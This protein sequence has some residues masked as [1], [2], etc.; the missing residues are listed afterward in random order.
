MTAARITSSTCVYRISPLMILFTLV[1]ALFAGTPLRAQQSGPAAQFQ[2]SRPLSMIMSV[3]PAAVHVQQLQPL[4]M[5]SADF[6]EDGVAD[7]VLGYSNG[8][9]G[10]IAF[11]RGNLDAIAPQTYASWLAA[12][13]GHFSSLFLPNTNF[14]PLPAQPDLIQVADMNGDGHL[15]I[16]FATRNGNQIYALL[17]DGSGHFVLQAPVNVAGAITALATF[18][19]GGKHAANAVMVGVQKNS[20]AAVALYRAA[21][22]ELRQQAEYA[23]PGVA[24]AIEVENLD[25]DFTP[26]AAIIAG[27]QLMVLHGN[28]ALS[29]VARLETLP[30]SDVVAVTAGEFIFDRHAQLQLS[31]LTSD[32]T[33]HILAHQGFDSNPYTHD[34]IAAARRASTQHVG[35]QNLAQIAGNTGGQPWT[36]IETHPGVAPYGFSATPAILLHGKASASGG[37]DIVVLN[38]SQQEILSVRHTAAGAGVSA[39]SAGPGRASILRAPL[40]AAAPI[41]ALSQRISPLGAEGMVVLAQGSIQPQISVPVSGNTLYVNTTVDTLDTNDSG[42]CTS[43]NAEPCSLRDAVAYAN[44]DSAI[45]LS[46]GTVD[47]I[48]VPS[49]TYLLTHNS[50]L[51]ASGN[52]TYH[53]D[54]TGPMTIIGVSGSTIIDANQND[55]IFSIDPNLDLAFN[56]TLQNLILQNAINNNNASISPYLQNNYGGAI[57]WEAFGTGNLN[58]I[59]STIQQSAAKW[60]PGGGIFVSNTPGGAG[61]LTITSSIITSNTTPEEGGGINLGYG[62]AVAITAS[63]FNTNTAKVAN[64]SLDTGAL[65]QGGGIFISQRGSS[66]TPQSTIVGGAFTGNAADSDGGGIYTNTGLSITGNTTISGN[67]SGGSGGG[68]FHNSANGGFAETTIITAANLASNKAGT[69]GGGVAVGTGTSASGNLLTIAGSR[70]YGNISPAG[71]N[72][73]SAGDPSITGA[74]GVTATENWWGCNAGPTTVGDGCDQAFLYDAVNGS[75]S[76]DPHIVLALGVSPGSVNAGAPITLT[77][78]VKNDSASG[79]PSGQPGALL[80]ASIAFGASVGSFSATPSGLIDATAT[81]AAQVTPTSAGIGSATATLDAQTVTTPFTVK[82]VDHFVVTAPSTAIAG[83]SFN[84][85]VTAK[86]S[87]GNTVTSYAGTVHFTSTDGSAVLPANS[88][89]TS[90][91]GSFSV[92]LRTSGSKTVSVVDTVITTATGTSSGITVSAGAATHFSVAAPSHLTSYVINQ[93]TVTALD[94]FGNVATAYAGT[95]QF[96]S[97]DPGYVNASGNGP[98]TSGVGTFNFALKTAGIQSITATDS[99]SATITGATGAITVDPGPANHFGI[100]APSSA[101]VGTPISLAVTAYDLFGNIATTY[102]GTIHFTTTDL[103]AVLP[104]DST[105]T[106]GVGTFTARLLTGGSQAI[107]AT[108][109]FSSGISGTTSSITVTLSSFVVTVATDDAIGVAANCPNGGG[110]INCSLRDAL[111][112]AT[113]AGAANITFDPSAFASPQTITLGTGG[114]LGINANTTI[115]G[116]TTG[117]GATLANLVTVSGNNQYGVLAVSPGATGVAIA[118]LIIN[119]GHN[120]IGDGGGINNQGTLSVSHSTISQNI[121][122]GNG[123]GIFNSGTLTVTNSTFASN[124]NNGL[125]DGGAIYNATSSSLTVNA[126][127]FSANT[128]GFGAGIWNNGTL[129]L[130]NSTLNGQSGFFDGA[131]VFNSGNAT[132]NNSTIYGNSTT[133]GVG[134]GIDNRGPLS[135]ANTIVLQN[136][137]MGT[138]PDL[139]GNPFSDGGGNLINSTS[140]SHIDSMLAPLGNYGGLTQ[141]MLPLPG[142][143][144][145][146]ALSPSSATGTDQRGFARTTNYGGITCQDSGSVQ[147]SYTHVQFTNAPSGGYTSTVNGNV[148]PAP[149]VALTENGQN[150]GGVP[151]TLGINGTSST[152]SGLGPLTTVPE[153]VLPIVVSRWAPWALTTSLRFSPSQQS[154]TQPNPCRSWRLPP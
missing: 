154:A 142:S 50:G 80:G 153:P 72:G 99:V 42:R 44:L 47:T 36:E 122:K 59:H 12:G 113:A 75:L 148:S 32:G 137:A 77:A 14:T 109:T 79:S 152:A 124:T 135:L 126:C 23:L 98:L 63:T 82:G 127:T 8:K 11:M 34:D 27:G 56:T 29:G 62:A 13:Q 61:K 65:G 89:L 25:S 88:T 60:G 140:S 149:I 103:N 144:A 46:H 112:A 150:I 43:G 110:G 64:N 86:D 67:T 24:T 133:G 128:A 132:I 100:S 145:I 3:H 19:P 101:T 90:G 41:A 121:S 107:T 120:L 85:T 108:D 52:R 117:S 37:E 20:G 54:I 70:I 15:D 40:N 151:I 76:T 21:G 7:L 93:L 71:S 45:N 143:P 2:M 87:G 119:R 115:T 125:S 136:V 134:G 74:G 28:G 96:T 106:S 97:S 58:I 91:V 95:V 105:L 17:G 69:A 18:K 139:A 26:D 141:T 81:S 33:L 16:V 5:A 10:A 31:V 123:G 1:A 66:A 48:M 118:N 147:S 138:N 9:G 78:S 129:N 131:G 4:A 30:V 39:N 116:P 57:D 94:P 146:C 55:K 83:T 114:T 49:G 51:D 68:I 22:G 84:V 53:I 92:T 104:G 102:A 111:A 38:P 6:D 73:L 130:T 35:A